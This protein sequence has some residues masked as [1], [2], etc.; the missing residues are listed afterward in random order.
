[1]N[2]K[3]FWSEIAYVVGIIILAFG[4]ALTERAE[5]G[6]SMVVAPAYLVH[7][8]VSQ[9]IPWFSFGMAEY[10]LQAI[11]LIALS[12]A[13][14]R[15]KRMYLFSFVTAVYYGLVLDLMLYLVGMIPLGGTIGRILFFIVGVLNCSL[16][17][18]LLFNTYIAPEAYEL[19]VKEV[20]A[21]YKKDINKT[22]IVYDCTSCIVAVVMSFIMFGFGHFE[23]V[24]YGTIICA[25][26]NGVLIGMFS[27]ALN[28]VFEF[29]DGLELRK[30]FS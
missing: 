30:Y 10:C 27:K 29:G 13:M 19:V 22:K 2:K 4:T 8:K 24:K 3:K 16:G 21:Q 14:K 9:Y 17:V 5:F 6:M 12:F 18:A 11:L 28:N 7:L 26:V 15:F 25:L 23:G 1:V 20:S